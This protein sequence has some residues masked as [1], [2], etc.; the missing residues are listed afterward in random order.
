MRILLSLVLFAAAPAHAALWTAACRDQN[1]QYQQI[2]GAEG[3]LHASR[4][5]ASFTTIKL[6]QSF[7]SDTMVCGAVPTKVGDNEVAVICADNAQQTLRVI[8]GAQLAKG[9]KPAEAP[10]LC[11]ADVTVN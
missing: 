8:R 1:V 11:Q 5:G 2:T 7:L 10:V 4:D 9:M 3:Y 6:K